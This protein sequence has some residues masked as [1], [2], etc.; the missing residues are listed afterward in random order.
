M[1]DEGG[2]ATTLAHEIAHVVASMKVI[3]ICELTSIRTSSRENVN[4]ASFVIRINISSSNGISSNNR[5][6][7]VFSSKSTIFKI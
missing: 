6:C 1:K 4:D 3:P 5:L 2:M 7:S